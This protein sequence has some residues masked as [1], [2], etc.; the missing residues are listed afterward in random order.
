V[1]TDSQGET[2]V[3]DR[4]NDTDGNVDLAMWHIAG[5]V[6]AGSHTLSV[7]NFNGGPTNLMISEYSAQSA[8]NPVDAVV[9]A[10]GFGTS[11]NASLVTSQG[12]DLIYVACASPAGTTAADNYALLATD[13]VVD[14]RMAASAP[15]TETATCPLIGSATTWVIQELALKH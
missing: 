3:L 13:P 9:G 10:T 5:V 15:G 1:A 12:S 8:T 11:A 14:F 6:N 7:S 2:V 4:S